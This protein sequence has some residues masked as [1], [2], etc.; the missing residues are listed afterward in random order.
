MLVVDELWVVE[1]GVEVGV[2]VAVSFV[3]VGVEAGVDVGVPLSVLGGGGS[4]T[5]VDVEM[6]ISGGVEV[7]GAVEDDVQVVSPV[8]LTTETEYEYAS[9]FSPG[10]RTISTAPLIWPF[11][12]TT[13]QSCCLPSALARKIFICAVF[14]GRFDQRKTKVGRFSEPPAKNC[15]IGSGRAIVSPAGSPD[16]GVVIVIF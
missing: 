14:A 1:V 3:E 6:T 2:V 15:M 7:L 10:R 13:F 5:T 11:T 12:A 8:W 9:A 4:L 16:V